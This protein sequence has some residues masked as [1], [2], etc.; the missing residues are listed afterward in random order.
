M[1]PPDYPGIPSTHAR[2]P[3][4]VNPAPPESLPPQVALA[5]GKWRLSMTPTAALVLL[6]CVAC[7]A[8][9]YLA[10]AAR[11]PPDDASRLVQDV[12]ATMA[13]KA[14]DEANFKRAIIDRLQGI[15][16]QVSRLQDSQDRL[17]ERVN[18]RLN[19]KQ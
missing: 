15:E 6:A 1:S 17:R 3:A 16:T 18:D 12:R 2:R 9:G 13:T 7:A 8:V 4:P 19:A 14:E 11:R 10:S 5:H